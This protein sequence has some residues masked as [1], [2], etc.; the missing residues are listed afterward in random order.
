LFL[1]TL[2]VAVHCTLA[3]GV[4]WCGA[5]GCRVGCSRSLVACWL[6]S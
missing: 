6:P 2:P 4:Q 5:G 1:A 3:Y